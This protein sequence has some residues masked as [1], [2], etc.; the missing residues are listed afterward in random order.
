MLAWLLAWSIVSD[1]D[2]HWS[3]PEGCGH[4]EALRRELARYRLAEDPE[5][6]HAEVTLAQLDPA[7]P[8]SVTLAVELDG[9]RIERHFEAGNCSLAISASALMI[10]VAL[11]PVG[12]FDYVEELEQQVA[13][14]AIEPEPEPQP[15]PEPEPPPLEAKPE[16]SRRS[17]DLV[18]Q[19]AGRGALGPSPGFG[20]ELFG[21]L[22]VRV[23]STLG[24]RFE[25]T[26]SF[27]PPR[28]AESTLRDDAGIRLWLASVGARGCIEPSFARSNLALPVCLGIETGVLAGRGFGLDE[29]RK[30]RTAHLAI[31][32]DVD[33]VWMPTRVFGLMIGLSGYAQLIRPTF[34]VEGEGVVHQPGPAGVR[35]RA[36]FEF[37]WPNDNHSRRRPTR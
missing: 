17:I 24:G 23:G 2:L 36:G 7:G 10:A 11:D 3:A 16:P 19:L 20:A 21:S 35:V 1:L 31:P 29:N 28:T 9:D 6:A 22:G 25:L 27:A 4:V 32:L 26:G 14:V 13:A 30:V 12:A 15:E 37:R 33:L 8:W 5:D 18:A 34:G